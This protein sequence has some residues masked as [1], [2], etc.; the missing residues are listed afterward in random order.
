VGRNFVCKREK[1]IFSM[2]IVFLPMEALENKSGVRWQLAVFKS[3]TAKFTNM[4]ITGFGE[5]RYV[6][7]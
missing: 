6:V 4:R 5:S 3:Y 1:L 7:R 2:F